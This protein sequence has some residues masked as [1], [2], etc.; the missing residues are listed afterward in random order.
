MKGGIKMIEEGESFS[1][2]IGDQIFVGTGINPSLP[3][4]G[5]GKPIFQVLTVQIAQLLPLKKILWYHLENR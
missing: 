1:F 4:R 3:T 5:Q 2:S